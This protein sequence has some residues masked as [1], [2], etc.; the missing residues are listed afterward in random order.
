MVNE[1]A[2]VLILKR[3]LGKSCA[4]VIMAGHHRHV[5]Q[6]TLAAFVAY[7]TVMGMVQHHSLN[8]AGA[9]SNRFGIENGNAGL[10]HGRR[11]AGHDDSPASILVI[12]KLLDGAL[13]ACAYRTQG[14]MPA[15]VRQVEPERETGVQQ[16]LL[17]ICFA[18]F[19]VD[20]DGS[21]QVLQ[22]QRF[23]FMCRSKSSRKNFNAL[24]RGSAA[25]GANAQKVCPGDQKF[26]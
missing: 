12:L 1:W 19:A 2:E 6:V 26:D 3:A 9:K 10:G 17:R 5:L 7:R 23:S 22:G 14:G 20:V 16:V 24:C 4:T 18:G 25:P 11:H 13:T 8:N 21:H 15:E